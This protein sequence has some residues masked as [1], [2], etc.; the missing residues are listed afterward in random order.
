MAITLEQM[1]DLGFKPA[2]KAKGLSKRKYDTL[3]F[4]LN[5]TDYIYTGYN[6]FNKNIDF[7]RLWKVFKDPETGETITFNIDKIGS[8][9]YAAVKEYLETAVK[10]AKLKEEIY[11][12]G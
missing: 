12:R 2:K 10:Q 6:N 4:R 1:K 8:L 3:I 5:D 7:K 11:G 9:T